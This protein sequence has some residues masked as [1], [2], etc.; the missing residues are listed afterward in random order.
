M[1]KSIW[2]MNLQCH[3]FFSNHIV[4]LT[5]EGHRPPPP[6]SLLHGRESERAPTQKEYCT[7]KSEANDTDLP[8]PGHSA[9]GV[10]FLSC[11]LPLNIKLQDSRSCSGFGFCA[12]V[13]LS[14]ILHYSRTSCCIPQ[15]KPKMYKLK[16]FCITAAWIT[17]GGYNL[18]FRQFC[19][20]QIKLVQEAVIC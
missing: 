20:P 13:V 6:Q 18:F 16:C 10:Y 1:W 2:L 7:F 4:H 5:T 17:F 11:P 14:Y 3:K 8:A 15:L 12:Q 9:S 19:L